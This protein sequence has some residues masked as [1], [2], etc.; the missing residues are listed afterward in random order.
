MLDSPW[1]E[2]LHYGLLVGAAIQLIAIAA[3]IVLPTSSVEETGEEEGKKKDAISTTDDDGNRRGGTPKKQPTGKM[4]GKD[5]R[6]MRK[7]PKNK[8]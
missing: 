6:G 7:R 4:K 5:N 8:A 3:I 1:E 2:L